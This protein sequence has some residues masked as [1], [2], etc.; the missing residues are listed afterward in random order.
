[1][2][3]CIV[4]RRIWLILFAAS[5]GLSIASQ[6]F[7]QSNVPPAPAISRT[8]QSLFVS[9]FAESEVVYQLQFSPDLVTW[10]NL[11]TAIIGN[12]SAVNFQFPSFGQTRGFFRLSFPGVQSA[13]F[14]PATGTLKVIADDLDNSVTVSRDATGRLL[15]N[16]GTI[17]VSGGVLTVSNAT[18]IQIFG[19][20]GA[21]QIT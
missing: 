2:K 11:G 3:H 21:D 5:A 16:G 7:A 17:P 1:M 14:D 18:V 6:A 19:R 13:T 4:P 20:A 8:N 9:W 10:V 12:G 15:I